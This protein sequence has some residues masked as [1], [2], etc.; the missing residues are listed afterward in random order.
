MSETTWH[1]DPGV[2]ARYAAGQVT[3]AV[4]ASTEAHLS[5][6]RTCRALLAPAVPTERLDGIWLEVD[7]RVDRLSLPW[8]ER[9]LVRCGVGE[10]TA[11]LLAATPSLSASWL[12]S[13]AAAAF[14]AASA[15]GTS[16][17]ALFA[18]LTVAPMLP[19]AGVAAAYGRDADPAHE[20]GVAAPY[21]MLRLLLLRTLTVVA[22]TLALTVLA[23][24]LLVD[25]GWVAAAWLLPAAA[26]TTAT[27]LLSARLTPVWAAAW[28]MGTWVGG[29]A[30]AWQAT[31]TRLAAFGAVGQSVALAVTLGCIAL[32]VTQRHVF[33]FDTRRSA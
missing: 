9:V 23:G 22:A 31:G 24:L 6:C 17:R 7:D 5:S 10:D 12:G 8:F 32:L 15:A 26:L 18:F 33:A 16:P 19:V 3:S 28:V 4:A 1:V 13:V 2:L 29:V 14:L 25:E 11:R 30:A 21:S 27:L 20:I